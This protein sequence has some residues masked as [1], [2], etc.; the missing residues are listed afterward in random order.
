MASQFLGLGPTIADWD[1]TEQGS[2]ERRKV[3]N[4]ER[5]FDMVDLQWSTQN[6]KSCNRNDNRRTPFT[7]NLLGMAPTAARERAV[8]RNWIEYSI[9]EAR[10]A[11]A[12]FLRL[13]GTAGR[14]AAWLIAH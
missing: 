11:Y 5:N 9:I 8:R 4:S 10:L 7:F 2:L 1:M 6:H 14:L 12:F 3:R 13:K